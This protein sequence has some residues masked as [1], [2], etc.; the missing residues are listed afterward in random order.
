[1]LY[2]FS[3]WLT[4][5]LLLLVVECSVVCYQCCYC[6][7][8]VVHTKSIR[9]SYVSFSGT[10]LV[11]V[12]LLVLTVVFVGLVG[13]SCRAIILVFA[14]GLCSISFCHVVSRCLLTRVLNFWQS[15]PKIYSKDILVPS[16]E[17]FQELCAKRFSNI[18]KDDA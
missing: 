15:V 11:T 18:C 9:L 17:F 12:F 16:I 10:L 6:C 4:F 13:F 1:M 2:S 7:L 8:F 14:V 3:F 5:L